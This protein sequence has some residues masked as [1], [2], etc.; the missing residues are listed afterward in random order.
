[1]PTLIVGI[2]VAFLTAVLAYRKG[3]NFI[4]WFFSGGIIG[5][6][7]LA[8]LPYANAEGISEEQARA[9][10]KRGDIIGGV[11]AFIVITLVILIRG[12][13]IRL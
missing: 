7:V 1:M 6:L 5:L 13:V 11:I 2:A 3:Y 10:K 9:R 4:L 8:F 12:R